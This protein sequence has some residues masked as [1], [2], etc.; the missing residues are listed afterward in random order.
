MVDWATV[1]FD[2]G[3]ALQIRAV[4]SEEHVQVIFRALAGDVGHALARLAEVLDAQMIVVGSRHGGFKTGVHDFFGG[5]VAVHLIHQ[6]PRSVVVI[7]LSPVPAGTAL[8]WEGH[9]R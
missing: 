9:H 4:A 8:P 3:L 1:V 7:P 2:A 6:Q 5:S